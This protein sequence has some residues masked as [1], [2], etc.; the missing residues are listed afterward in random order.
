MLL[1]ILESLCKGLHIPHAYL[2]QSIKDQHKIPIQEPSEFNTDPV[3]LATRVLLTFSPPNQ[4]LSL[5]PC[6]QVLDT[7]C[8]IIV[9][10]C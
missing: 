1:D 7:L 4:L 10:V 9:H 8:I 3:A 5:H 2:F 6:S